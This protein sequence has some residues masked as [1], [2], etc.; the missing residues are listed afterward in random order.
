MLPV[1]FK[2]LSDTSGLK[3]GEVDRGLGDIKV[4]SE[5]AGGAVRN[6]AS[7][8]RSGQEPVTALADS[9]SNLTRAFG[10]GVGATVA[11]VGVVE[12]IKSFISESEKLNQVS[13]KLTATLKSF[14][15]SV[16]GLDFSSA[17]K[18]TKTLQ[19]AISEAKDKIQKDSGILAKI[20]KTIADAFF[21]GSKERAVA[22]LEAAKASEAQ[23]KYAAETASSKQL[24]LKILERKDPLAA[25]ELKIREKYAQ[26]ERELVSTGQS[27]QTIANN[28]IM[29]AM[30]LSGL[31]QKRNDAERKSEEERI[32]ALKEYENAATRILEKQQ[33]AIE[34][35]KSGFE[36]IQ[37]RALSSASPLLQRVIEAS[38][39]VGI[40]GVGSFA[41]R[42][43]KELKK[44]TDKIL[45]ERVGI[46]DADVTAGGRLFPGAQEKINTI[47]QLEAESQRRADESLANNVFNI[48]QAVVDLKNIIEQKLGVPILK[49]AY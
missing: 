10:L 28:R 13:E 41:Q 17:V 6:F 8:I 15:S 24:E 11:V 35:F 44:E 19:D 12:V 3:F 38:E 18:Q 2:F 23:A 48:T 5:K 40:F 31:E 34:E 7:I 47:L 14:Q 37:N 9:F 46:T 33:M 49:S 20:G 25:E 30:E 32:S 39:N 16:G 26:I 21:G 42:R 27:Q 1:I 29:L 45:L 22:N 36:A 43:Q 4:S